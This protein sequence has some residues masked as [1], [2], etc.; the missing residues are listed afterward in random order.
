MKFDLGP[1]LNAMR[2]PAV[3]L[4]VVVIG[5]VGAFVV[6][7]LPAWSTSSAAGSAA[8][9]SE[10]AQA[11]IEPQL[12]RARDRF[13][14]IVDAETNLAALRSRVAASSGTVADVVSTLRAAVDAA[15]IRA[16]RVNYETQPV[17]ELGLTQ[18]QINLPVRGNYRDLRRLLDEL[19][20][21]PMFVVLERISASTPSQSDRT[22]DLMM[23][24]AASVF[25]DPNAT[26]PVDASSANE[27]PSDSAGNRAPT[28]TGDPVTAQAIDALATRLRGLPM[29][30]LADHEFDLT[31]ARLD[32][33]SD[34]A[35]PTR[36]DLFSFAEIRALV[37]RRNERANEPVED[38]FVP[39]PVMPYDLI[40]VNRTNTGL[41][42]TLVDGPLVLVVREG[43]ILPDGY[44]VKAIKLMS[45]ILEAGDIATTIR[46]RPDEDLNQESQP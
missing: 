3:L 41:L 39:E 16:D 14:R 18:L 23:A 13:G 45:V 7:T 34:G 6:F 25:L 33:T 1:G 40:G 42:A 36:R 2:L 24:L 32:E 43:Q 37:A 5:N 28:S 10:Q 31:L 17:P 8:L 20:D 19:L 15:G 26:E 27:T 11:A 22:G 44:R 46:L 4:A 38:L 30:P 9:V 29:I 35:T 21:G 12:V